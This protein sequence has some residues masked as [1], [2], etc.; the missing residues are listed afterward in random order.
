MKK[1]SVK[2]EYPPYDTAE[3]EIPS[4]GCLWETKFRAF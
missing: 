3:V 1:R 4:G 2:L